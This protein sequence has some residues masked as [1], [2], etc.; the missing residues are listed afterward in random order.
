VNKKAAKPNEYSVM[1]PNNKAVL[2]T[3][4]DNIMV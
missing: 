1:P 4:K 3:A 2:K